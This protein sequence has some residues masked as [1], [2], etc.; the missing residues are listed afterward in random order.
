MM[1]SLIGQLDEKISLLPFWTVILIYIGVLLVI[2]SVALWKKWLTKG[3]VFGAL[4][5]G[6]MVLYL[7]GF[8]AFT[9]FLFFFVSCSILSKIKRSHNSREKKGSERD[10]MQVIANGFP[11]VTA[12]L[13]SRTA[14]FR[15]TAVIGFSASVAEAVADTFSSTFG[16]MSRDDPVSIITFTRV[17]KGI[18]GGVTVLGL[19]AG[20][21][22]AV[23]TA[24]LHFLVIAPDWHQALIISGAGF[25]ASVIDS[26]LGA[27]LQEHFRTADGTLTEKEYDGDV[28]NV[29]VRGLPGFDNDMVNLTSGFLAL[30]LSLLLSSLTL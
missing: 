26:V 29:R 8:S 4:M 3:G 2:A 15:T 12:L 17:P 10:L 21:G 28:K 1:Q 7:G 18:S 27:T 14:S 13:L 16:I 19:L 6:F 20:A 25:A 23:I 11:A 9:L 5:L 30:S 22:G 24:L